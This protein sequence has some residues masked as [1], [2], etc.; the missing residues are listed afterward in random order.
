MHCRD[1]Y[2]EKHAEFDREEYPTTE[3]TNFAIRQQ[4]E[5]QTRKKLQ[6]FNNIRKSKYRRPEIPEVLYFEKSREIEDRHT[7]NF[8]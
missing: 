1:N 6:H 4:N 2:Y 7:K 5:K 8:R 3:W